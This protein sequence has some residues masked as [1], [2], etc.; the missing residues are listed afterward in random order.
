MNQVG[1]ITEIWRYPV[2]SVGGERV[3][4][5]RMARP[6]APGDRKFVLLDRLTGTPA[7][8]EKD[9][10]WRPALHLT[11]RDIDGDAPLIS[12]PDGSVVSVSDPSINTMLSDYFGFGVVVGKLGD[13]SA[14]GFPGAEHRHPHFP[15]HIL[16]MGS[17][18]RLARIL[19]ASDIDTRRFRPTLLIDGPDDDFNEASWLRHRLHIGSIELRVEEETKRCGITLISQPGLEEDPE[20]LRAILRHNRRSLGVYCSVMSE[21]IA[22]VGDMASLGGCV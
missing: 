1:S 11:A 17:L 21:G 10:R 18:R 12:F 13:G 14:A 19:P 3:G 20:I 5:I 22:A 9:Q 2:A 15:V 7:A 4:V 6:G 16:T 8:P